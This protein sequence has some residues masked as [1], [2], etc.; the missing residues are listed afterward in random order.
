MTASHA[1]ISSASI[2]MS[3]EG[4]K[5]EKDLREITEQIFT[6]RQS[7]WTLKQFNKQSISISRV[8]GSMGSNLRL[9]LGQ[10]PHHIPAVCHQ[11]LQML[12]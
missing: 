9:E 3:C 8:Y 5:K 4:G 2:W 1:R 12:L 6:I 10:V 7:I 11:I